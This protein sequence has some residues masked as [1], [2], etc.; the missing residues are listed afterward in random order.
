MDVQ[1]ANATTLASVTWSAADPGFAFRLLPASTAPTLNGER[2]ATWR[3]F[4]R[5]CQSALCCCQCLALLLPVCNLL[6][7]A[8]AQLTVRFPSPVRCEG[9]VNA[10]VSPSFP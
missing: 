9:A 6:L 8:N 7:P 4:L 10:A 5:C 1:D 2:A 3:L